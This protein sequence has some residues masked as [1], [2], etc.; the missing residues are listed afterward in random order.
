M[1]GGICAANAILFLQTPRREQ[2]TPSSVFEKQHVTIIR[3]WKETLRE[4]TRHHHFPLHL[5]QIHPDLH[6][7]QI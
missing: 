3:P 4:K 7:Q 6:I 5:H 1:I 2:E